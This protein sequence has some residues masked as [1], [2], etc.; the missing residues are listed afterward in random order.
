MATIINLKAVYIGY[1]ETKGFHRACIRNNSYENTDNVGEAF[2]D[3]KAEAMEVANL[4]VAAEAFK[5]LAQ[6]FPGLIDGETEVN[7]ADLVQAVTQIFHE[8]RP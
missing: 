5:A 8:R 7:G 3:T 4:F 6:E 2:G 1:D